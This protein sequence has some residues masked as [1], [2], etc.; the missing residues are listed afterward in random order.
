MPD[1][2]DKAVLRGT[3]APEPAPADDKP[4]QEIRGTANRDN[5]QGKTHN[6]K[7]RR[8]EEDG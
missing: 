4:K 1:R 2:S 6:S 5:V 7:T 3:I 8:D